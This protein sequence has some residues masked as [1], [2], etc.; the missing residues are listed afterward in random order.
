M[1][2]KS[3]LFGGFDA[4][5]G[6]TENKTATSI[7]ATSEAR[8]V[9]PKLDDTPKETSDC[10]FLIFP[11]P[12]LLFLILSRFGRVKQRQALASLNQADERKQSKATLPKR[13]I[14]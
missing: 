7:T 12:F 3:F 4:N 6:A 5:A 1:R 11:S 9:L 13:I 14:P 10:L 2:G 8:R